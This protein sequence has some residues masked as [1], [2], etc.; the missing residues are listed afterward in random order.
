[1]KNE[2]EKGFG[3]KSGVQTLEKFIKRKQKNKI[4]AD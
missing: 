1:M 4:Q 2:N 3:S